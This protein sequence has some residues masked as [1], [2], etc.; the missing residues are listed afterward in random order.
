MCVHACRE[1]RNS[2]ARASRRKAF[3]AGPLHYVGFISLSGPRGL[4]SGCWEVADETG[5]ATVLLYPPHPSSFSSAGGCKRVS[6]RIFWSCR[7]AHYSRGQLYNYIAELP[8][9]FTWIGGIN[10]IMLV[11]IAL[12]LGERHSRLIHQGAAAEGLMCWLYLSGI[13]ALWYTRPRRRDR[14]KASLY[15]CSCIVCKNT[16]WAGLC[17]Y[18]FSY[19]K[20]S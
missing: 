14:I 1:K 7:T 8:K 17:H 12:T 15:C 5:S 2:R 3:P 4:L 16:V 19:P 18:D 10:S 13:C 11:Y 6:F 20:D 9:A